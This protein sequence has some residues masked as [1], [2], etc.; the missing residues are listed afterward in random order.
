MIPSSIAKA[1]KSAPKR[2]QKAPKADPEV[3]D[4]VYEVPKEMLKYKDKTTEELLR[5]SFG[6]M[7]PTPGLYERGNLNQQTNNQV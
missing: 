4:G 5:N 7:N 6:I 3:E 1:S 2:I